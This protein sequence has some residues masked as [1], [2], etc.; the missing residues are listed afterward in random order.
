MA[1][2][3]T[4][5]H[6]EIFLAVCEEGGASAAARRLGVSQPSVSQA[7]ID[8]EERFGARLFDREGRR[9]RLT[10]R[11]RRLMARSR[12]VL[13]SVGDL[14]RAMAG[15]GAGEVR[16]ASS[17]TCGTCYLPRMLARLGEAEPSPSVCVR[18]VDSSSVERAVAEGE[19]DMGLIEGPVHVPGIVAERFA[20]DELVA[21]APAGRA[22]ARVCAEELAAE[23]LVLRERGSGVRELFEA[24]LVERGLVARPAWESVS[25]EA[26]KAAVEAGVGV[27]VLPLSLVERELAEGRLARL[28]VSDLDLGRDLLLV[29]S[30]RRTVTPAMRALRE[31]ALSVGAAASRP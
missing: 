14:E 25:T 16:V 8:L 3:M 29:R 5:R 15:E 13:A 20:S 19:A 21:V 9:M 31:A 1:G 11:G 24:A 23:R 22:G 18:V 17:I 30:R 27:S 7:V 10:E 2:R 12:D 28:E 26:L 4:I 6:L